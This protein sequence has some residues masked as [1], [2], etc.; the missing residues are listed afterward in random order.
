MR[1]QIQKDGNSARIRLSK[2]DLK[3]WNLKIGDVV[4][5]GDIVKIKRKK[6]ETNDDSY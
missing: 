4:D 6:E 2:E 3:L 5:I 1:K